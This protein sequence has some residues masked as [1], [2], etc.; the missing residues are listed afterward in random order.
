MGEKWARSDGAV[1]VVGNM[2]GMPQA[3][4]QSQPQMSGSELCVG[5][6]EGRGTRVDGTVAVVEGRGDSC[7]LHPLIPPACLRQ[8]LKWKTGWPQP[9]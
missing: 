1:A 9:F 5:G 2:Q 3:G 4:Q 6:G 7:C 8:A